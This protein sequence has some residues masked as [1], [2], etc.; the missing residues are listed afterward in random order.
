MII[1]A[2]LIGFLVQ[3]WSYAA[4][5]MAP[6]CFL[7]SKFAADSDGLLRCHFPPIL[8]VRPKRSFDLLSFSVRQRVVI[9]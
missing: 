6:S 8:N 4:V 5:A 2:R 9:S 3:V 1:R 7:I